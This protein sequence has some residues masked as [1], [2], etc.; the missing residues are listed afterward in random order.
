MGSYTKLMVGQELL[1]FLS[2]GD[3][4]ELFVVLLCIFVCDFL[5]SCTTIV[6]GLENYRRACMPACLV[7]L[8]IWDCCYRA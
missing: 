4:K 8:M 2:G 3:E 7:A 1:S 5:S 6:S